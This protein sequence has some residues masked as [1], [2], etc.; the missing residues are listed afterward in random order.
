M[1]VVKPFSLRASLP[2]VLVHALLIIVIA[3]NMVS[4]PA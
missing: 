4:L 3:M 2:L 1:K